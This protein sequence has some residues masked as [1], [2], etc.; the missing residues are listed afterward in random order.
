M[1][2]KTLSCAKLANTFIVNWGVGLNSYLV[3]EEPNGNQE[4]KALLAGPPGLGRLHSWELVNIYGQVSLPPTAL[5]SISLMIMGTVT[6][7]KLS[8]RL[9]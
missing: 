6:A 4:V 5:T 8:V 3:T 9:K 2:F 7:S 1:T